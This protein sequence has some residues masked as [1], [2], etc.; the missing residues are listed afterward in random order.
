MSSILHNARIKC[1]IICSHFIASVSTERKWGGGTEK[2]IFLQVHVNWSS[3]SISIL[4]LVLGRSVTCGAN[5]TIGKSNSRTAAV[6][7]SWIS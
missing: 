3:F 7:R 4:K 2:R 1:S 6:F 5:V